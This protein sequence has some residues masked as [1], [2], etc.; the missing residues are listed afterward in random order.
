MTAAPTPTPDAKPRRLSMSAMLELLRTRGGH[1]RSSVSLNR[2]AR[3]ATQIEVTV[4]TG[5]GGDVLTIEDAETKAR[6]VYDRLRASY[7]LP[8][9]EANGGAS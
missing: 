4:R 5:D 3:G 2:N 9:S 7:P 6:E 1:D 8:D